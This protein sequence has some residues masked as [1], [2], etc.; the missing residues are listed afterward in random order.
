MILLLQNRLDN[1][2]YDIKVVFVAEI[3]HTNKLLLFVKGHIVVDET[4]AEI[5]KRIFNMRRSGISSANIAKQLNKDGIL[6]P[7]QYKK[8]VD[9]LCREWNSVSGY[10]HWTTS[11]VGNI[12]R[13][14]RYTG[15]MISLK[16]ERVAVGSSKVKSVKKEDRIVAEN[17]HEAIIAKSFLML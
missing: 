10:K 8:S 13:D 4:A 15:K 14:E 6:H 5:V 1:S 9:P 3:D 11:I 17:T 2:G 7:S 12:L 16:H